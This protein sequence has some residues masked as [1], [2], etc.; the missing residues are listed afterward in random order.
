MRQNKCSAEIPK[1]EEIQ[2][3]Q[4][5]KLLGIKAIKGFLL[6]KKKK[7]GEEKLKNPTR[8]DLRI[9]QSLKENTVYTAWSKNLQRKD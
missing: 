8:R 4:F 2:R 7:K 6:K 3:R 5:L 9:K 1:K